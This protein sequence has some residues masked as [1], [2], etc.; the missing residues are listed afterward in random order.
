MPSSQDKQVRKRLRS[1]VNQDQQNG[2]SKSNSSKKKIQNAAKKSITICGISLIS[3]VFSLLVFLY[4]VIP[5]TFYNSPTVR[6]YAVFLN[7]VTWPPSMNLS[8]I[9]SFGLN[10]ARNV[11]LESDSE[12]KLGVWHVLPQSRSNKVCS[13]ESSS[14]LSENNLFN[15][16]KLIILYAHG[17]SGTRGGGHRVDLY[18]LL[19]GSAVDAHIITFDYRGYGDSTWVSPTVDGVVKDT[20]IVYEWL[21]KQVHPKR[22]LIWGHSLGTGVT[23]QL[24]DIHKGIEPLGLV[25]ET[26]FTTLSEVAYHHP[27][28]IFHRHLPYF[29]AFFIKPAEHRD[30]YFNTEERIKRL[31]CPVLILHAEDDGVVPYEHGV[32]LHQQLLSH[33]KSQKSDVPAEFKGFSGEH[34]YGHKYICRDPNLPDIINEFVKKLK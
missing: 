23:V 28:T 10:C 24:L 4:A 13:S 26:P 17:N 1:K 11:Y 18:K 6:R 31:S 20:Q 27:L 25:L 33:R 8:D 7:F 15:D 29:D 21:R 12:V 14:P 30:T 2:E 9:E 32:R 16:D 34:G 19:A 5:L 3:I 22:I